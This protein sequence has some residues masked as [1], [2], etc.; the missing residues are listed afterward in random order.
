MRIF[1]LVQRVFFL[2][3]PL[4]VRTKW[5]LIRTGVRFFIDMIVSLVVVKSGFYGM[6]MKTSCVSLPETM[7]SSSIFDAVA[8]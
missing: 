4:G 1:E 3:L 5:Y 8:C 2:G 7:Q 6:G